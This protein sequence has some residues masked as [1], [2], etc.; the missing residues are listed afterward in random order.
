[1]EL[2]IGDAR[3]EAVQSGDAP[4]IQRLPALAGSVYLIETGS[5][6]IMARRR[7]KSPNGHAQRRRASSASPWSAAAWSSTPTWSC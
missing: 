2:T 3:K 6:L 7:S 1:M 4:I 5:R